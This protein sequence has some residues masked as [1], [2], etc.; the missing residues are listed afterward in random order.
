MAWDWGR[1]EGDTWVPG[2]GAEFEVESLHPEAYVDRFGFSAVDRDRYVSDVAC[3][4]PCLG[5]GDPSSGHKLKGWI[6]F[7]VQERGTDWLR[8]EYEPWA[9]EEDGPLVWTVER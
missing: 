5:S 6:A 8:I 4:A 1:Q 9:N 3:G 2:I 7:P